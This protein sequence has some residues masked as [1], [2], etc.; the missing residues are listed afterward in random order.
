MKNIVSAKLKIKPKQKLNNSIVVKNTL[1]KTILFLKDE[2]KLIK[3][4]EKFIK[5]PM[6]KELK[7]HDRI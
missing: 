1:K 6:A 2:K 7:L 3:E 5:K 4:K